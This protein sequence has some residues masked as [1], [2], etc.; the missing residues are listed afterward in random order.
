MTDRLGYERLSAAFAEWA[1]L[2]PGGREAFRQRVHDTSP[3]LADAFDRLIAADSEAGDFLEPPADGSGSFEP[4]ERIGAYRLV[5]PVGD[6]GMGAVYL[7]ARDDAQ[8]DQRVAVKLIHAGLGGAA[9]V[10]FREERQIL[11]SLS[12]PYIA[13]LIDGGETAA[14][15]PYLVMEYVAGEAITR[16]CDRHELDTGARLRLCLKVCDAVRFAHAHL[17]VHCDIKPSNI[18]VTAEGTP[19]LLDFGIARLVHAA[20]GVSPART[21]LMLTPDYASPEQ[22]RNL[23]LTTSADLYSLAVVVCELVT[24]GRPRAASHDGQDLVES[25]RDIA[26]RHGRRLGADL[27]TVLLK[28]LRKIPSDRYASV[29]QFAGDL[30]RY[31]DRRPILARGDARLYRARKFA[32][33]YWAGVAATLV[34]VTGLGIGAALS[35]RQATIAEAQRAAAERRFNDVRALAN[36]VVFE[37]D[38]SLQSVPGSTAARRLVLDR[39]LQ[40]LERLASDAAEPPLLRELARGYQRVAEVQGDPFFRNLG[41]VDGAARSYQRAEDLW[42]QLV[43]LEAGRD[44]DREGYATAITGQADLLW[45]KGDFDAAF[46]RYERAL[47]VRTELHAK[48]PSDPARAYAASRA[49]YT[50][51]QALT[52]LGRFGEARERYRASLAIAE[53]E[54]SKRKEF[55]T[56]AATAAMKL[57]DC[58]RREG[59]LDG[60]IRQYERG[61][62]MTE[63][64]LD[65]TPGSEVFERL[66]AFMVG[67]LSLAQAERGELSEAYRNARLA[68]NQHERLAKADSADRQSRV[69]VATARSDFGMVAF[70]A[71]DVATARDMVAVSVSEFESLVRT[72]SVTVDLRS[73][74]GV[75]LRRDGDLLRRAGRPAEAVARYEAAVARLAQTP[76]DFE[77]E[78]ELAVA[79]ARLGEMGG[80]QAATWLRQSFDTWRQAESRG[81]KAGRMQPGGSEAVA[82]SISARATA[83]R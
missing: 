77:Y 60:A 25:P 59:D 69:D 51:G 17:V 27:D 10:R 1:E 14:G 52:K 83:R 58:A 54:D 30:G 53:A 62:A 79:Q 31:L 65:E 78:A 28:A 81:V 37:F 34:A 4:G 13:H 49:A 15:Q 2:D 71:G 80:P 66:Q 19:K 24:G 29:E 21:S 11:A 39:G 36:A 44:E 63:A 16:Y 22:V 42:L 46:Q 61:K 26:R 56:R 48:A 12:H 57:G 3:A 82:R 40:Y 41:D 72:G 20:A 23:P 67:R 75:A 55:P 74:F 45:G 68:L 47:S 33:R 64:L 50:S 8:F 43:R 38:R 7:A 70:L 73:D 9:S 18:L 6:G 76:R 35:Q 5:A 32:A